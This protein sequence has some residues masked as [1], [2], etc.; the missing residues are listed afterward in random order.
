MAALA[1][2]CR[3]SSEFPGPARRLP[4]RG[5]LEAEDPFDQLKNIQAAAL[6]FLLLA[7]LAGRPRLTGL[8]R[9][10]AAARL[11]LLAG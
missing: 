7:L 11:A 6:L 2:P 8:A 1:S 9:A 5:P 4:E 10:A 3:T